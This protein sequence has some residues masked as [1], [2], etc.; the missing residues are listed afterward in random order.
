MARYFIWLSVVLLLVSCSAPENADPGSPPA[1]VV[2]EAGADEGP[3][4]DVEPAPEITEPVTSC[5]G[6]CGVMDVEM[7]CQCDDGCVTR[8]DC[9][10]DLCDACADNPNVP[11]ACLP[12]EPECT[13]S[14]CGDDG[15]GGSCG[16][17]QGCDG[18]EASLCNGGTCIQICCPSC[19]GMLCGSD[20]CGGSCGECPGCDG[21][22]D[23]L[24]VEGACQEA[25]CTTCASLGYACGDDGCGHEC[26]TCGGAQDVCTLGQC[27]C[28]PDCTSNICGP[29]GCGQSCGNAQLCA[30]EAKITGPPDETV[31]VLG[32]EVAFQGIVSDPFHAA[33]NLT[34]QWSIPGQQILYEGPATQAG[35]TDVVY[36]A[37]AE[38]VVTAELRVTNPDGLYATATSSIHVCNEGDIEN[39]D[40]PLVQGQP[41]QMYG[42]AF[43]DD[44]GAGN[45][46]IDMTDNQTWADGAVFNVL[47]QVSPGN[48]EIRLRI[49][50]GGGDGGGGGFP[51][52]DFGADGYALTVIDVDTVPEL[53]AFINGA[54]NGGCLAYGVSGSCGA[55]A[56]TAFHVEFDT[57]YNQEYN[58]PTTENHIA[59]TLDGDPGNHLL[60]APFPMED[61]QWHDVLIKTVG[62]NVLVK[63]DG[64]TI[65]DDIIPTFE[66]HGG[67]IGFSG[68]TGASS[69]YHRIDDL[70]IVQDCVP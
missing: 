34:V 47:D 66:F 43:Q 39:F 13:D 27:M 63:V 18:P 37:L 48:V 9:C 26:G 38:G 60:W 23:Q 68:S 58:D 29:D 42:Y 8:G 54:Q 5:V 32:T 55:M 65:I 44:D 6:R 25:C 17:C 41:W 4:P 7:S 21:P 33:Q 10:E 22:D 46:W 49:N 62:T 56:V 16:A 28:V 24:C 70:Q 59:I 36:T 67:Y 40:Q 31:Y 1:D 15:C 50:T 3:A 64:V 69:N 30:P 35:L 19:E 52:W 61:L 20:G 45:G 2:A 57:Y 53:E 11:T 14:V 12:C 51:G